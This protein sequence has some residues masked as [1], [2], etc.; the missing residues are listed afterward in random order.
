MSDSY[1]DPTFAALLEDQIEQQRCACCK[2]RLITSGH[3]IACKVRLV[4]PECRKDRDGFELDD[5]L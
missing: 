5:M 2:N 4:F 1:K 3:G